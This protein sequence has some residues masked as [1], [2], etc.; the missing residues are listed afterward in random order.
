MHT[1]ERGHRSVRSG[2][3][4]I[5]RNVAD[6]GDP[7]LLHTDSVREGQS[8]AMSWTVGQPDIFQARVYTSLDVCP[9]CGFD[10]LPYPPIDYNICLCCGTEFSYE[11]SGVTHLELRARWIES[12]SLWWSVD[13]A[14]P[15][16]WSALRQIVAYRYTGREL[17]SQQRLTGDTW[18]Q[19]KIP[20][21]QG[22]RLQAA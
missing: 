22:L 13:I 16:R 12:G 7:N 9:V 1:L 5:R 2:D 19:N 11:D 8:S 17:D 15:K 6:G 10:E 20:T 4:R 21:N 3:R 14:P 18:T